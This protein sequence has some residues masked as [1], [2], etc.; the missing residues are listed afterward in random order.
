[1]TL[2]RLILNLVSVLQPWLTGLQ[3]W[4]PDPAVLQLLREQTP[5]SYTTQP[6]WGSS[7][8]LQGPQLSPCRTASAG[9]DAH[10]S[11]STP[12]WL[13]ICVATLGYYPRGSAIFFISVTLNTC[14]FLSEM[15]SVLQKSRF[16]I[17]ERIYIFS[18]YNEY[19]EYIPLRNFGRSM[20]LDSQVLS[21]LYNSKWLAVG[22]KNY[23]WV[24][25]NR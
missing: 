19:Y 20:S 14:C 15:R 23:R 17:T 13:D 9:P 1:M 4:V 16:S 12:C 5:G 8:L 21:S 7:D 22:F 18:Q 24:T 2:L 25:C 11:L 3:P 6:W 10:Q